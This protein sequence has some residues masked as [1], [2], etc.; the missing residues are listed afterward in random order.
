MGVGAVSGDVGVRGWSEL[1]VGAEEWPEAGVGAEVAGGIGAEQPDQGLGDDSAA[2]GT[3]VQAACEGLGFGQDVVP[4]RRAGARTGRRSRRCLIARLGSAVGTPIARAIAWPE[5]RPQVSWR[6][7]LR[8][9]STVGAVWVWGAMAGS[10]S[11]N[12]TLEIVGSIF[13]LF[14]T[15]P[16]PRSKKVCQPM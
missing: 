16:S 14:L 15:W 3:E 8:C 7:R 11:V 4:E 2:D 10:G 5:G 9:G 13:L 1:E 12:R 6:R